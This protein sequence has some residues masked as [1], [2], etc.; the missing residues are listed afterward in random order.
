MAYYAPAGSQ[1]WDQETVAQ[2]VK[3]LT[4]HLDAIA[5]TS[6]IQL[7]ARHAIEL[8]HLKIGNRALDAGCGAGS[9]FSA[10]AEAVGPNGEIV[11][12][13]HAP[14]FLEE[15]RSHYATATHSTP[16]KL[17]A[18][19][20]NGMPFTDGHFDAA[21]CERM[22]IHLADPQRALAEMT[23]VVK[24]G[25]WVVAVEPD[26]TGWRFDLEDVDAA[27]ALISG[28]TSTIRHPAMGLALNRRMAAIGLVERQ[29]RAVTEV[30][31]TVEDEMFVY[32]DRAAN[33]AIEQGWLS[34]EKAKDAV[35]TLR[36]QV[37]AGAYT[38]YSSLF[39]VAGRVPV[40]SELGN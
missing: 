7:A 10:V 32:F 22:L 30:E 9:F 15:A 39:V 26:L 12:L 4:A 40:G 34:T 19:D 38:S 1:A 29:V 5:E 21:H 35:A 20:V 28:F 14:A 33:T 8:M 25:G 6:P 17:I 3:G 23:R 11:G 36:E 27:Q 13:D 31:T 24:P 37:A 2:D 16:L 18:G